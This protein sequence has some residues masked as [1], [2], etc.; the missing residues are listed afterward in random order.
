MI[1]GGMDDHAAAG[2]MID[3]RFAPGDREATKF[4]TLVTSVGRRSAGQDHDAEPR[5]SALDEH[6]EWLRMTWVHCEKL[7]SQLPPYLHEC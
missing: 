2:T 1:A 7:L 5:V 3:E 6:Q 4:A